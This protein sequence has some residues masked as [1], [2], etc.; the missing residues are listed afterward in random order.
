[1]AAVFLAIGLATLTLSVDNALGDRGSD[2]P[3]VFS[4]TVDS[5]RALLSTIAGATI[6]FAAIAFS[7]SL[8]TIQQASS[9]YSPRVTHTLF[10]DPI[11]KRVMA[12]VVGTFTYC[13]FVLRSVRSPI[14]GDGSPVIPNLSVAVATLLGIATILAIVLFINHSAHSMDVSEILDRV[15]SETIQHVRAD[16]TISDPDAP[17][18]PPAPR[19]DGEHRVIRHDTAGW[20]QQIDTGALLE[21]IDDGSTLWVEAY[22]GRYAVPGTPLAVLAPPAEDRDEV[23]A[24]IRAAVSTGSTRT[25]Q[26][27]ASYGLR[28][29]ADVA[30]KALSPGVNDPTTAQDAIFHVAGVLSEM[31]HRDPDQSV[32]T[33]DRGRTLVLTQQPTHDDLVDLALAETRRASA[34]LPAV[35]IYLLEAI[36]LLT[37]SLKNA[38]LGRRTTG[39]LRQAHL[40]V[41]GTAA[42]DLLPS[43][44]DAVRSAFTH[45][46]GP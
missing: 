1:M 28:Q 40:I 8:L 20:I 41:D 18:A 24:S 37:E 16:W 19:L 30:L 25:M 43:D 22:P 42:T 31:L 2:L 11:N 14:E 27:D 39:L 29:L 26:Q 3:I 38:D 32:R 34:G 44:K 6:T 10:R 5:A 33:D 4:S 23:E 12:L 9:Q 21:A 13:V 15:Q 46:F 45:R 7:V 36:E 35:S 17:P